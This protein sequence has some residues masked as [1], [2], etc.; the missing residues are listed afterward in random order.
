MNP[1]VLK[2]GP[3]V[4]IAFL[5]LAVFASESGRRSAVAERDSWKDRAETRAQTIADFK[6]SS[7]QL[8]QQ[9]DDALARLKDQSDAITR[10]SKEGLAARNALAKAIAERNRALASITFQRRAVNATDQ[11]CSTWSHYPVCGPVSGGLRDQ[12][13]ATRRA[14]DASSSDRDDQAGIRRNPVRADLSTATSASPS[15]G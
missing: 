11:Q 3:Y 8:T 5:V 1:L 10:A 15:P 7:N 6:E 14:I 2:F 9:R 12:W 13:E 4:A